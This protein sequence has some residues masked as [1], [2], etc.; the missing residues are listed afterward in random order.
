MASS[1]LNGI[2]VHVE[3]DSRDER[4]VVGCAVATS[5]FAAAIAAVSQLGKL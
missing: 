1:W 5:T 3:E 2:S 4:N